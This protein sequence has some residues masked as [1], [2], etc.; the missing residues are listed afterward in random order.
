MAD[1]TVYGVRLRYE[2]EGEG[3]RSAVVPGALFTAAAAPEIRATVG[4][5]RE[6]GLRIVSYDRRNTGLSDTPG[7]PYDSATDARD[8]CGLIEAL[9]LAPALAVGWLATARALIVAA[10]ERPELFA[11]LGLI[12]PVVASDEH[13]RRLIE[14][15][16]A[17][18]VRHPGADEPGL[19]PFAFPQWGG[20]APRGAAAGAPR[21]SDE[22]A[23]GML[24]AYLAEDVA[25]RLPL[26][27]RPAL[28]F[29]L[30]TPF[31]GMEET[32]DV[33]ARLPLGSFHEAP[34]EHSA[35]GMAET[36]GWVA[37]TCAREVSGST[38]PR[39]SIPE[40]RPDDAPS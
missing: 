37:R 29:Y 28:V 10:A 14:A 4:G 40:D 23:M 31:A 27:D 18:V 3:E 13:G 11:G 7:A 6:A 30:D 33:A 2:A 32:R 39:L 8:L 12:V 20:E 38:I 19:V 34:P 15:I 36:L 21:T 26:V 22:A 9:E 5:L 17:L 16:R 1:V 35:G 24:D 25:D